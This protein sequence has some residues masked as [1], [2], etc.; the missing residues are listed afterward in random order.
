MVTDLPRCLRLG[1]PLV[2]AAALGCD[3]RV[4]VSRGPAVVAGGGGAG[5]HGGEQAGSGCRSAPGGDVLWAKVFSGT[6]AVTGGVLDVTATGDILFAGSF[7]GTVDLGKGPLTS[8][9][10]NDA[11]LA[12]FASDGAPRWSK[13]FGSPALDMLRLLAVGGA[14]G[15]SVA[16]L[17][18]GPLDLGAGPLPNEGGSVGYV[19]RYAADGSYGWSIDYGST[20]DVFW[21]AVDDAGS[22]YSSRWSILGGVLSLEKRAATGRLLWSIPLVG[23]RPP[24]VDRPSVALVDGGPV[25]LGRF[26]EAVSLGG[27]RHASRGDDDVLVAAFAPDGAIRWSVPLGAVGSDSPVAC[28]SDAQGNVFV[29]AQLA[30]GAT[31]GGLPLGTSGAGLQLVA[32]DGRGAL[33]WSRYL[34]PAS[35]RVD[36]LAADAD[37]SLL[38][39]GSLHAS[40]DPDCTDA[41]APAAMVRLGPAGEY[42]WSRAWPGSPRGWWLSPVFSAGGILMTGAFEGSVT[43]GDTTHDAGDTRDAFLVNVSR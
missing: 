38:V 37:G 28:R 20:S 10:A 19:A 30:E 42:R 18:H 25:I 35:D 17:T 2:L 32:L 14:E 27:T 13:R 1:W 34:G 33:R 21:L 22:V 31:L 43:L 5:G 6:G 9:G 36:G 24:S 15:P 3:S 39:T 4:A 8:A 16:G 23:A 26:D 12:R 11:L 29:V 40:L 41:A 7:A